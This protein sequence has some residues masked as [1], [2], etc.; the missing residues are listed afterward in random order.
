MIYLRT[1][2]SHC[3]VLVRSALKEDLSLWFWCKKIWFVSIAYWLV[4]L[5]SSPVVT[6]D[7]W[8]YLLC[9][10]VQP[11]HARNSQ[12]NREPILHWLRILFV[13]GIKGRFPPAQRCRK[14][15]KKSIDNQLHLSIKG[16]FQTKS[17][18]RTFLTY[19]WFLSCLN[20]DWFRDE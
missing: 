12:R 15:V 4:E 10:N 11:N 5:A 16:L 9:Y 13:P 18:R 3:I 2:G 6:S 1:P 8:S 19:F 7:K 20:N 17:Y 14:S